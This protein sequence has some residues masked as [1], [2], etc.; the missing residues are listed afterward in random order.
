M[1]LAPIDKYLFSDPDPILNIGCM[2]VKYR[3][4]D[5]NHPLMK[6]AGQFSN[7]HAL[8]GLRKNF[9]RMW[10]HESKEISSK[11]FLNVSR[12]VS[13]FLSS[14]QLAHALNF[15]KEL[16]KDN[17]ASK[18]EKVVLSLKA[19]HR[20]QKRIH[21]PSAK[22]PFSSIKNPSKQDLKLAIAVLDLFKALFEPLIS[23]RKVKLAL[24][25]TSIGMDYCLYSTKRNLRE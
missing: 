19:Y 6:F 23:S 20:A 18:V 15:T 24:D 9:K 16:V 4:E 17:I 1:R 14:L 21:S 10:R 3:S 8:V 22:R 5:E 12:F 2:I 7:Y 13:S 11:R 25:G